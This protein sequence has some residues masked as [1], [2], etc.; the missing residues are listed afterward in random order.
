MGASARLNEAL[1]H[2]VYLSSARGSRMVLTDGRVLLDAN[3]SLGAVLLGHGHPEVS[4]AV[5]SIVDQGFMCSHETRLHVE[6]AERLCRLIPSAERV[7]FANTGTEANQAALRLARA[8][9]GRTKFIKFEG[10]FHGLHDYWMF[11]TVRDGGDLDHGL[12]PLVAESAGI[13]DSVKPDVLVLPWN[14]PAALEAVF[15]DHGDTIAAVLCE[16]VNYNS[17]CIP[18]VPGFLEQLRERTASAGALLIFDEVLSGFRMAPGGAQ[19]Y[20][21]VTPD[22]STFGKSVGNG[23]PIGVLVGRADIMDALAPRGSAAHS[24]TYTGH[25]LAV[26]ALSVA[27]GEL[28]DPSL[29]QELDART[30]QLVEGLE[31][32]LADRGIPARLQQLGARFGLYLGIEHEVQSV[33]DA[34][35]IAADLASEFSRRCF[36]EGVYFHSYGSIAIGHHGISAAHSMDDI[37]EIVERTRT[38]LGAL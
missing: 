23:L 19:A 35:G 13:P 33:R 4:A 32:A 7:R 1:G 15:R 8:Y 26:A 14:D 2:P 37:E 34:R 24:G 9:T 17:G 11:N 16:P 20:Y 25:P 18:P 28:G 3:M 10:H 36:D 29:H 5:A 38:A 27:L 6:S 21:G 30:A 22:L 31:K 12:V